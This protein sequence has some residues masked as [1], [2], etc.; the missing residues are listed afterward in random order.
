MSPQ[1]IIIRSHSCLNLVSLTLSTLHLPQSNIVSL[2]LHFLLKSSVI[3]VLIVKVSAHYARVP[4]AQGYRA[5]PPLA[6][7]PATLSLT[8]HCGG[9]YTLL[10]TP[11]APCCVTSDVF[12]DQENIYLSSV[13]TSLGPNHTS[14]GLCLPPLCCFLA[15]SVSR[16]PVPSG[17]SIPIPMVSGGEREGKGAKLFSVSSQG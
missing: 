7:N 10:V 16:R 14:R 1:I 3:T 4:D 8:L 13:F 9:R 5:E 17:A 11:W 12:V 6:P 2:G 15:C